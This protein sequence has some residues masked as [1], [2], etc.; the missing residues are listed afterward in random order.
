MK[1]GDAIRLARVRAI[2]PDGK[3]Y[4]EYVADKD[5]VMVAVV[6]GVEPRRLDGGG[7]LDLE[8]ALL[9]LGWVRAPESK[10]GCE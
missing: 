8:T 7:G 10:E 9:Q 4:A 2:F 3:G 5:M 6:L 1:T